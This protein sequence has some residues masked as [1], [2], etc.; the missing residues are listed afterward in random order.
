VVTTGAVDVVVVEGRTV[1]DVDPVT[2]ADEV[3]TIAARSET[4]RWPID[5]MVGGVRISG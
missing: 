2:Q 3:R 5:G 4:T 1:V